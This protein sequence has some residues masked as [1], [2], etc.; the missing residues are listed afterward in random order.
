MPPPVQTTS[1]EQPEPHRYLGPA[2]AFASI[3]VCMVLPMFLIRGYNPQP[4]QDPSI[5]GVAATVAIGAMLRTGSQTVLRSTFMSAA[6]T[7]TRALTRRIVRSFLPMMM[8]LFLPAFRLSAIGDDDDD[9]TVQKP[10]PLW[11]ALSLGMLTLGLSFYGVIFVSGDSELLTG[12]TALEVSCMA[13]VPL[14]LHFSLFYGVGK[15]T[16]IEIELRT[17]IDGVL[18]QGYFTGA[19]SYLPLAS[20][21]ELSGSVRDKGICAAGVLFGFLLAYCLLDAAGAMTGSLLL[22]GCAAQIL[23]YAFV[24]SFPLPPLDGSDVWAHSRW[25]W[26]AVWAAILLTFIGRMPEAFYGIL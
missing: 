22:S 10:Q 8:R 13:T 26:L 21:I 19:G 4:Q 17:D 2:M 3:M 18:L 1:T 25:A 16:N 24:L 9:D 20:D 14:L 6:R 11:W 5:S 12:M 15:L 7:M 23:L